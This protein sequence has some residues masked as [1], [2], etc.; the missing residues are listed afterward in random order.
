MSDGAPLTF[1]VQIRNIINKPNQPTAIVQVSRS[2]QVQLEIDLNEL[3][4]FVKDLVA[5]TE[6]IEQQVGPVP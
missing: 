3:G 4:Q 2:Q 1:I 5:S 6:Y